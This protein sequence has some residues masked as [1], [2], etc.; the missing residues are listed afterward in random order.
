MGDKETIDYLEENFNEKYDSE[1][2][3]RSG[4]KYLEVVPKYTSKGQALKDLIKKYELDDFKLV[5]VGD[6]IND[7]ELIEEA[8]YGFV[9]KNGNERLL[10]SAKHI[11]PSNNDSP[12]SYIV[13]FIENNII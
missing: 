5:T 13:K 3:I 10:K 11:A 7:K 6:N 1:I 2:P 8:H 4:D 12:I 9:V